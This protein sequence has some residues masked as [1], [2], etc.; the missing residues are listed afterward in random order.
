MAVRTHEEIMENLRTS[1]GESADDSVI[2]LM[3]DITDTLNDLENRT[4]DNTDWRT[5]YEENDSA[6]R[7]KYRDR[8]FGVVDVQEEEPE[9][10]NILTYENLFKEG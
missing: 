9:K 3:E 8:F 5:R 7:K 1:F 10:P 4:K 2:A 6:W